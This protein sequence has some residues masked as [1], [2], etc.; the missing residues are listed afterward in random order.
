MEEPVSEQVDFGALAD[1]FDGR[2][3]VKQ[4]DLNSIQ[5]GILHI[6]IPLREGKHEMPSQFKSAKVRVQPNTSAWLTMVLTRDENHKSKIAK[7]SVQ[8]SPPLKICN[9]AS[10][11]QKPVWSSGLKD[12]FADVII[13]GVEIGPMGE[14]L[15]QGK[16]KKGF[17]CAHIQTEFKPEMFPKLELVLETLAN[18][19]ADLT[20]MNLSAMLDKVSALFGEAK[21]SLQLHT[22]APILTI[23][24]ESIQI[25]SAH[26]QADL[27]V[28]VNASLAPSGLVYVRESPEFQSSLQ[29][30][31]SRAI[32][33]GNVVIAGLP[34][35]E[36][37]VSGFVAGDLAL[38]PTGFLVNVQENAQVPMV[39]GGAGSHVQASAR[40]N[41]NHLS[42][43]QTDYLVDA[44]VAEIDP[45]EIRALRAK[46][47]RAF[48]RVQGKNTK[49]NAKLTVS[50]PHFVWRGL[51]SQ[52]HGD[53]DV[54]VNADSLK[55][56][57]ITYRINPERLIPFERELNYELFSGY[58]LALRPKTTGVSSFLDPLNRFVWAKEE[59]ADPSKPAAGPLGSATWRAC[60]ERAGE[61]AIQ[62]DNGVSLLRDGKASFPKRLELIDGAQK[63]IFLQSLIFKDDE[64]GMATARALVDA[65]KRGVDVYVI[66]DSLGNLESIDDVIRDNRVYKMLQENGVHLQTYSNLAMRGFASIVSVVTRHLTLQSLGGL[67]DLSD[68]RETLATCAHLAKAALGNVDIGLPP[69]DRKQLHQGLTMMFGDNESAAN[70]VERLAHID[71]AHPVN[72]SELL[73]IFKQ[74]LNLNHRWHEKYLVVDGHSAILGGMNI[75]D[76]YLQGGLNKEIKAAGNVRPAWRD[77]D[78]LIEGSG[79]GQAAG[80][81]ARNWKTLTFEELD[82]PSL[83]LV[84]LQQGNQN[85]DVQVIQSRPEHG[86][87]HPITNSKIETLKA[88]KAGDKAYEASAYFLPLGGLQAYGEALK[89]AA[90]R[91]VDVRIVTNSME[92]TDLPQINAAATL[93]CYRDLMA[94]GVRIFER[95]GKRTMHQKTASYGGKVAMVGSFNLDNRSASLNSESLVVVHNDSFATDIEKMILE[96]MASDVAVEL[97]KSDIESSDIFQEFKSSA[98]AMLGDLM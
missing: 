62:L 70:T 10:A 67:N 13:S 7:L 82:L 43:V 23:P 27:N 83:S 17:S 2:F 1:L 31:S 95:T 61:S 40:L 79:A 50:H 65:H 39:I 48:F 90:L 58:R 12:F 47:E 73:A 71:L 77:T 66:V 63:S 85:M 93:C 89:Q 59:I 54:E 51:H 60:M 94:A 5:N 38:Q 24:S 46:F 44:H 56:G 52:M 11:F 49:A 76:E 91:G 45:I 3:G 20:N 36:P 98:W 88:L 81:F 87:A 53:L 30:A 32:F 18:K 96:D 4:L 86:I 92:S 80:Y 16:I 29:L 75:A 21:C 37:A 55:R 28:H 68:P 8:I 64:T 57:R 9:P 78:V 22:D 15:F 69:E 72:I 6:S 19:P 26:P 35:G 42:N 41:S 74:L 25:H 84:K 97:K 33:N 34:A 14:V